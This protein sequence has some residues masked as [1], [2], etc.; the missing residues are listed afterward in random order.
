MDK[1]TITSKDVGI[2][3][4]GTLGLKS[5]F[6]FKVGSRFQMKPDVHPVDFVDE[7]NFHVAR[8]VPGL[9]YWVT[10]K[11]KGWVKTHLFDTNMAVLADP[12]TAPTPVGGIDL[13][14]NEGQVSASITLGTHPK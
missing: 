2:L 1:Q 14:A 5:N 8:Y 4:V 6:E 12:S 3:D 9:G 7:D 11:N 10:E 13:S